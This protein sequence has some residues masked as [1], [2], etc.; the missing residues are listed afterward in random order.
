MHFNYMQNK[1]HFGERA[2][3]R[4]SLGLW[5]PVLIALMAAWGRMLLHQIFNIQ[6]HLQTLLDHVFKAN[7]DSK[8]L[9]GRYMYLLIPK[10]D[11][12]WA[13]LKRFNG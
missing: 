7:F 9:T 5:T 1:H 10:V 12:L 3:Y 4:N 11:L 6:P 2:S 13:E 8:I